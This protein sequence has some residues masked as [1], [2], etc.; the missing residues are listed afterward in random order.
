MKFK[1]TLAILAMAGALFAAPVGRPDAEKAARNWLLSINPSG[2]YDKVSDHS[3]LE[4]A[5]HIFNFDKGGFVL[6]AADDASFPIL[7]YSA[8]GY[9]SEDP[10]KPNVHFWTGM[11]IKGIR[12]IRERQLSSDITSAEWKDILEGRIEK[13]DSKEVL[14]LLTTTWNQSPIYN[15][16]CPMDGGSRSVVGC[17]ATAMAQIMNY[18]KYPKTG[19]SSSS[20]TVPVLNTYLSVDYYLSRYNYDLMPNY[21]TSGSSAEAKHEVAQLSYHA[22]VAVEMMYGADGSGAYSEDVPYA[23]KTYFKYNNAVVHNYRSAYNATTWRTMLQGQLD[24]GRPIYYSGQGPDGGH[25]FVCDG[26][27]N[28]DY[29]HFNWGWGGSADGYFSI[30][31]LNPGGM[32]FNDWQAVVKDII[33]KTADLILVEPIEDIQTTESTYQIDLSQHFSSVS[34]DVVNYAVDSKSQISGLQHSIS[35]GILTFTKVADGVSRIIVTCTTRND[36][37]F[38]EF[39]FQFGS[40]ALTAGFGK[41]YNFNS[42]AYLD[43]GNSTDMNSLQQISFSTWVKF[44]SVGKD[45]G[46][47]SKAAGTNSGWYMIIQSNNLLKFSV[48][49]K[50]GITRRIYSNAALT[51]GKWYHIDAVYDGKDLMIYIDGELD[52]IKTTYTARSD[53]LS[54]ADKNVFLGNSYGVL[55]DGILD[56]TVIWD[57]A[58]SLEEIRIIM[59]SRPDPVSMPGIAAYWPINEGFFDKASDMT[60]INDGTFINN[61]LA[62]WTESDAPLYFFTD[63]DSVLNSFLLGDEDDS[64]TFNISL[65]AVSGTAQ[66]TDSSA[67]AFSYTPSVGFTGIDQ[68]KYAVIFGG[69]TTPSKTVIISVK[70]PSGIEDSDNQ[71]VEFELFQNYPNPFNP[72]TQI[73][74]ALAKTNGIKLSVFNSAG[75][76]VAELANGL[77]NAGY[78]TVDFDASALN[79]GVYYYSLEADGRGITKK[80]LL[81]K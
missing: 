4:K 55:L 48:K 58:V 7:G 49:T 74:F 37:N 77:K 36:N 24:A 78:H 73:R 54:D 45:Q 8:D 63:K 26:Y 14:P 34:G 67:G 46:I 52:N 38:E 81:I 2:G 75:Q 60:G 40:G 64:R 50:D 80:M 39:Y 16:Y 61:D 31:N 3:E 20:Y 18:H 65:Q 76:K 35:G 41:S 17:V 29:Y 47:F 66:I 43:A 56:E 5:V 51:S 12:E 10:E 69:N 27:Q 21:L 28:S 57:K 44:N 9:F 79:S 23:L 72:V 53:I 6:V 19:K 11:Y 32:T 42:T 71:P 1:L 70:E 13:K 22:G 33:P 68:F 62:N 15:M 59:S 25:A 30:D